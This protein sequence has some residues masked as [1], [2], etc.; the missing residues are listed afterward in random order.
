MQLDI[1]KKHYQIDADN[2]KKDQLACNLTEM[3]KGSDQ[4]NWYKIID[5]NYYYYY[6]YYYSL[7]NMTR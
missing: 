4:N 6:Y 5:C 7:Y 1:H 3:E 2:P